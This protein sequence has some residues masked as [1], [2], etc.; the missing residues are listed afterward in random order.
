MNKRDEASLR[1]IDY[2]LD[3]VCNRHWH[4]KASCES[5]P[6]YI[7]ELACCLKRNIR[8]LCNCA[9][10]EDEKKERKKYA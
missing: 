1:N 8:L 3:V 6:L 2:S 5:C 9:W 7:E 10:D 4:T